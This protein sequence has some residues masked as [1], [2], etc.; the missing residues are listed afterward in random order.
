MKIYNLK[1]GPVS[2]G[3]TLFYYPWPTSL[4]PIKEVCN[5]LILETKNI[6]PTPKQVS[7]ESYNSIVL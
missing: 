3:L 4:T 6:L 5:I 7:K 2:G 1:S